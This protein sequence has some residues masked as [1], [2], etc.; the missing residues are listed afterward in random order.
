MQGIPGVSVQALSATA[1]AGANSQQAYNDTMT[2]LAMQQAAAAAAAG[3]QFFQQNPFM[4][5]PMMA[6]QGQPPAGQ[7]PAPATQQAPV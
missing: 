3:Q 6:W 7:A 4:A 1:P 2:A 5:H